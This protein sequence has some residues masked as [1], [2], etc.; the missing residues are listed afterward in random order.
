VLE[1]GEGAAL[2]IAPE[3]ADPVGAL[4]VGE[5]QDVEQL[6]AGSRTEGV[7]S[8]TELRL[9][10]VQVHGRTMCGDIARQVMRQRHF[11]AV[12]DA[13]RTRLQFRDVLYRDQIERIAYRSPVSRTP[14]PFA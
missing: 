2:R 8:L 3:L 6:G 11:K 13:L 4:E 1:I 9:E 14:P 7:E 5:G 12:R 10:V